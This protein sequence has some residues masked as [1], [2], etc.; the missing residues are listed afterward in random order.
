MRSKKAGVTNSRE[1]K[2]KEVCILE[3]FK[4]NQS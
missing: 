4:M 2:S 3:R 1:R